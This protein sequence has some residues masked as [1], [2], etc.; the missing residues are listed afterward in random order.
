MSTIAIERMILEAAY[1]NSLKELL[2]MVMAAEKAFDDY[3]KVSIFFGN[4]SDKSAAKFE[5]SAILSI[6]ALFRVGKIKNPLN[7]NESMDELNNAMRMIKRAYPNW[8]S[9]YRYWD[10]F[11]AAFSE[12]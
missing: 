7:K 6:R 9:A 11:Y 4:K 8:P 2:D 12:Q 1:G 5:A 3:G 10:D